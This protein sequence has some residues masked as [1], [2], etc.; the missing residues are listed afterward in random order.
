[1]HSGVGRRRCL[2]RTREAVLELRTANPGLRILA[3]HDPA[4]AQLLDA[5]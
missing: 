2:A 5:A 1:V 3:A 4:A